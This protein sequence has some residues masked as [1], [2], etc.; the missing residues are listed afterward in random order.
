MHGFQRER[1][2]QRFNSLHIGLTPASKSLHPANPHASVL[3]CTTLSQTVRSYHNTTYPHTVT[4]AQSA[5]QTQYVRNLPNTPANSY[6]HSHSQEPELGRLLYGAGLP[7]RGEEQGPQQAG[8][9][10]CVWGGGI[11]SLIKS[12]VWGG[13]EWEGQGQG[14]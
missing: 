3:A 5:T 7:V 11:T 13:R 14:P 6:S 9:S 12:Q 10:V 2:P 1:Q 8:A 4:S